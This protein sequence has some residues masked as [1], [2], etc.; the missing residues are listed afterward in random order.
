MQDRQLLLKA[1][2]CPQAVVVAYTDNNKVA[3][4]SEWHFVNLGWLVQVVY[5]A[6]KNPCD[7][8]VWPMILI[9]NRL[10]N[11]LSKYMFERNF[12][13]RFM[14][15]HVNRKNLATM[16]KT[17][18]RAVIQ[19]NQSE[20]HTSS[21]SAAAAAWSSDVLTLCVASSCQKSRLIFRADGR[22][23]GANVTQLPRTT[24]QTV[25][26]TCDT[27]RKEL[28]WRRNRL[29]FSGHIL[30]STTTTFQT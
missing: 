19:T 11:S 4:S 28:F 25:A 24:N 30:V 2:E 21:R 16:L 12:I 20:N 5:H 15:Y 23:D 29:V 13:K 14:N 1:K 27:W 3:S 26:Y 22:T 6:H 18:P 8:D 17:I 9:F 10:S 7:L